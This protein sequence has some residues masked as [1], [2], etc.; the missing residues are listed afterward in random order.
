MALLRQS[1]LEIS[2]E[3]KLVRRSFLVLN[4]YL[5]LKAFVLFSIMPVDI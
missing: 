5:A 3:Q 2:L 1:N 4:T